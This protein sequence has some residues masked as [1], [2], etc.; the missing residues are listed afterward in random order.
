MQYEQV[1]SKKWEDLGAHTP[2]GEACKG[3]HI[4]WGENVADRLEKASV[5]N[6]NIKIIAPLHLDLLRP[7]FL[8]SGMKQKLAESF[9]LNANKRWA[10]FKSSFT[11]ADIDP[12]RLKMNENAAG[13]SLADFPVIHTQSRNEILNWLKSALEKDKQTILIYR[14]HPDELSLDSVYKLQ[15]E[16]DNFIVIRD[17]GVKDWINASDVLYTWYSTSIVEAHFMDKP[18]SIL[19]PYE[20][21]DSFDS[22]LLKNGRFIQ[23]QKDFESDYL[24]AHV[25]KDKAIDGYYMNLYYKVDLS[26]PSKDILSD[27]IANIESVNVPIR[28][29]LLSKKYFLAKLK[30]ISIIPIYFYTKVFKSNVFSRKSLLGLL[31]TE[32]KNQ[33][34]D[35]VEKKNV[36]DFTDKVLRSSEK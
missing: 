14:P 15:E 26:K 17:R 23:S 18:Y 27:Y 28:F 16:F 30:S 7:E 10:L 2:K 35:D 8:E 24:S 32:I 29:S 34:T 4:C 25:S 36:R 22:V 21:P 19:R 20:L 9:N 12:N 1:L 33:V 13:I 31:I 3:V 5:P 11:Y 6:E